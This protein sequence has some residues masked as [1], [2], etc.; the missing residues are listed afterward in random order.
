MEIKA[1]NN[2]YEETKPSYQTDLAIYSL[3]QAQQWELY[4]T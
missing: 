2:W 1:N 3:E 4:R